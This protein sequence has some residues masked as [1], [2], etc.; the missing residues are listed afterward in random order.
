MI[1]NIKMSKKIPLFIVFFISIF[2]VFFVFPIIVKAAYQTVSLGSTIR[3]GDF[4]Y[5]DDYSPSSATCS[6]IIYDSSGTLQYSGSM[7]TDPSGNGWH[8]YDYAV[9]SGALL[10]NWPTSMSCADPVT[11]DII[12][13]DETFTV[14]PAVATTNGAVASSVWGYSTKAITSLGTAAADVWNT[15]L[16]GTR[17]LSTALLDDG[18]G[19][20]AIANEADVTAIKAKTDTINWSDITTIKNNVATLV[21]QVGTGNIAAIKTSTDTINWSDVTGIVTTDGAIKAKTDTINWSD[22]TGIK[23][24]TDTINWADVTGIKLN[25]D[26][27]NWGDITTIKNNVAT[28]I[29]QIGTGNIAAI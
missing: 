1:K 17:S 18:S 20:D 26:T 14:I 28:L 29:T 23:T 5:N 6:L 9:G 25:T 24:N 27:I 12:K 8:Y 7:T 2:L 3:V 10:G 21:T 4:V 15:A 16:S 19:T 13:V 11:G 22:V